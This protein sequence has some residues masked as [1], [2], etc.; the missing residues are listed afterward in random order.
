MRRIIRNVAR[1]GMKGKKYSMYRTY[2][3][4]DIHGCCSPCLTQRTPAT[5]P[6]GVLLEIPLLLYASDCQRCFNY[7]LTPLPPVPCESTTVHFTI[8]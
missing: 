3:T 8:F 7:D 5:G 6:F 4:Y 1:S 2:R